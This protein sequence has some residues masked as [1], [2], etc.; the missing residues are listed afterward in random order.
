LNGDF[1]VDDS[2]L[3]T[4]TNNIGMSSPTHTD[5]DINGDGSIDSADLDLAFAQYGLDLSVVT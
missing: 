4:V 5:G 1:A 3:D 2:D